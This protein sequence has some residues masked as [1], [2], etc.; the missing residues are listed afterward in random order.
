M[1]GSTQEVNKRERYDMATVSKAIG[2]FNGTA[3]EDI[4]EWVEA[5]EVIVGIAGYGEREM[6]SL[7]VLALRENAKS[8]GTMFVK[9]NPNVTW[10]A[11]KNQL[12]I[13]FSNEKKSDE[14]LQRFLMSNDIISYEGYIGL[15]KDARVVKATRG[16]NVLHLM[17]LVIAKSPAGLKSL[18]LQIAQQGTEWEEFL[19]QAE[20]AAWMIF[21]SKIINRVEDVTDIENTVNAIGSENNKKNKEK[22]SGFTKKEWFCHIHGKGNHST[23]FCKVVKLLESKGW[24]RKNYQVAGDIDAIEHRGTNLNKDYENSYGSK[25]IKKNNPFCIDGKIRETT[26]PLL[27]DTGA[28]ATIINQELLKKC[29]I[30]KFEDSNANLRSATG[31]KI[32]VVGK[33]KNLEIELAGKKINAET[34]VTKQNPANYGIIGANTILKNSQIL[35]EII[36]NRVKNANNNIK[37]KKWIRDITQ[38]WVLAKYEDLFRTEI[39]T[40]TKCLVGIHRIKTKGGPIVQRNYQVPRHWEVEID[41]QVKDLLRCG[42]I[43]PSKSEWASRIIPIRK[44][45]GEIRLC[46]DFRKINDITVRDN[47]P[48]PRIDEILDELGKARVFSILDAT[49]GYYQ[50]GFCPTVQLENLKIFTPY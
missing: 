33:I 14:I 9:G 30:S 46:I 15:L 23:K 47:Y 28:D 6:I 32:E 17:R 36:N 50:I 19:R 24:R 7:V 38:E 20:S 13:R 8:W 16:M 12:I 10:D 18:L 41:N 22:Y 1:Q 3:K 26:I 39:N 43:S 34:I 44:K 2:E 25:N 40:K 37:E 49:S 27:L 11:F 4:R 31:D 48:L 42:V 29:K 35:C 45:N 21:P 5:A